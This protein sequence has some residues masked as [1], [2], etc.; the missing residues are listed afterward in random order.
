MLRSHAHCQQR[1]PI[2]LARDAAHAQLASVLIALWGI[3]VVAGC[4]ARGPAIPLGAPPL[5]TLQTQGSQPAVRHPYLLQVGDKIAVKF[6]QN[7]DL[8][9]E[10]EVRPDGMISLQLIGDVRAAGVAPAAL[11]ARLVQRYKSELAKPKI[12]VIVRQFSGNQVY[13]GGQ[14]ARQ[15]VVPFTANLTLC[16]AIQWAGGFL[17]TAK[18]AQ[19]IL[20]RRQSNGQPVAHQVDVARI[21]SGVDPGDDVPLQPHDIVFV[22]KTKIAH[23][24]EFVD[25]YIRKMLPITPGIGF[26]TF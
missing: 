2:R 9:E 16:E 3:F 6:Y 17:P 20:I 23:V 10:V 4:A 22:P 24:N 25:Q 8:D 21:E 15:G 12:S 18:R 19:V 26:T 14:V 1:F 13:I 7:P 11:A 5:A